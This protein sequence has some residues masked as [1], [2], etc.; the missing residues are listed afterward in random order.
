[1]HCAHLENDSNCGELSWY[2]LP[3]SPAPAA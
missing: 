1:V 2:V 3:R